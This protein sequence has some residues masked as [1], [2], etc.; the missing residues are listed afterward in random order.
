M[1][2]LSIAERL[3]SLEQRITNLESFFPTATLPV[4]AEPNMDGPQDAL[5]R[6]LNVRLAKT[7]Y[8]AG[9][10]TPDAVRSAS[11]EELLAIDGIGDKALAFIRQQLR[12]AG[13]ADLRSAA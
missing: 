5:A 8:A 2:A 7:L 13:S 1:A 10:R 3:L 11:D 9:L 6:A 12:T 4:D